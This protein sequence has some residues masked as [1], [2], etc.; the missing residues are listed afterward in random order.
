M[1]PGVHW[2]VC[3]AATSTLV[4]PH[5]APWLSLVCV[6]CCYFCFSSSPLW[7]L[8]LI[9]LFV[10]LQPQHT[11]LALQ[12]LKMQST[13]ILAGKICWSICYNCSS[14]HK[15]HIL[16]NNILLLLTEISYLTWSSRSYVMLCSSQSGI[17]HRSNWTYCTYNMNNSNQDP[18]RNHE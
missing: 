10:Q 5:C 11:S 13:A 8:V 9:G 17:R 2:S 16:H 12:T 4:L 7:A 3:T 15:I 18:E 14:A 1:S 6:Y